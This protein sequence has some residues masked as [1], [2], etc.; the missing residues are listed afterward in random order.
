MNRRN[1]GLILVGV[2]SL[3]ALYWASFRE[4]LGFWGQEEY[5]HGPLIPVI[6]LLLAA[7]RLREAR[8]VLRSSWWGIAPLAVAMLFLL[9]GTFSTFNIISLY[10]FILAV[11]GLILIFWGKAAL[12]ACWPSLVY[13]LFAI[14]LPNI[15]YAG[16]S[17]DLQLLSSTLGVSVLDLMGLPVYQ[18]GNVIDLGGFKLQVVDA[19]S[20]LRYLFPLMSFGYLAACLLKDRW[21]KLLLLMLSTVVITVLMNSLRI[22][23]IGVTVDHWGIK[24]ASGLIHDFEGWSIFLVCVLVLLL[25][26]LLLIHLGPR[27]RIRFEYLTWP[28]GPFFASGIQETTRPMFVATGLLL[29]LA[30]VFGFGLLGRRS[31]IIPSHRPLIGFPMT[32][33]DWH[34]RRGALEG[35]ILEALQISDYVI[36]DYSQDRNAPPVDLYIAYYDVQKVGVVVHSPSSCIPGG[37]W[38]IL[39]DT[40]AFIAMAEKQDIKVKRIV[41]GMGA[42]KQL[43]Y[44]W[45][46]ERGRDITGQLA[47]KWWLL[48]DSILEHR[49][50]GSLIRL[51]TPIA[52]TET[53][54]QADARLTEFLSLAYPQIKTYLPKGL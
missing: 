18:E 47:L 45:F 32:I 41:I 40:T 43:V 33:G 16:L 23:L 53:E 22:A 15:V 34:G 38:K 19:C 29:V 46:D 51:V 44:Y 35:N 20:G 5:S 11:A 14:P 52:A 49:T 42:N 6:A 10:G 48:R 37:G 28:K 7:H 12:E 13:L 31:E 30:V 8:P 26:M 36:S 39:E 54:G 3:F 24:M 50:D 21:W 27:G 4:L 17:S 9:I 25:E 2:A 1:H